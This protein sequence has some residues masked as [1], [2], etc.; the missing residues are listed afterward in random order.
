RA[1]PWVTRGRSIANMPFP[2]YRSYRMALPI[3]RSLDPVLDRFAPDVVHVVTPSFLGLY[4][5]RYGRRR[6][7]PVVASFHTDFVSL[8][9]YYGLRWLEG[10]G[11]R[12]MRRFY[13][14]CALTLAPSRDR[15]STRLNSSHQIISYAVFCLK[16]NNYP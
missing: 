12:L 1:F 6:G 16:K 5:V 13:N 14:R 15:K 8:F 3:A 7:V 9:R 11:R 2:L 10:L 4:G